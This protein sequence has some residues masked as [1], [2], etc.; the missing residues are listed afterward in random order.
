MLDFTASIKAVR[1]DITLT[2]CT[3]PIQI[4][5]VDE[6]IQFSDVT[7][8]PDGRAYITWSRIDGEL[9][10]TAQTF[11]HKIRVETAPG[12]GTFGPEHVIYAEDNA[13]PFGGLLQANDFRVATVP[14]SDVAWVDGH[15]R[16]FAV[17]DAC[18]VRLLDF[19]CEY[20]EIKLSYSDDPA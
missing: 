19:S 12:S 10:G 8:G 2:T 15:P 11:M 6:D 14:K 5:T 4:S 20:P 1:C 13:I 9:E 7:I 3:A 16:V 18:K 17:W